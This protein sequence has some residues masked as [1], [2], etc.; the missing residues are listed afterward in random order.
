M[1]WKELIIPGVFFYP[2]CGA[3]TLEPLT[4][5]LDQPLDFIFCDLHE[6]AL[7]KLDADY[8]SRPSWV[9]TIS[10]NDDFNHY[11]IINQQGEE[12]C[13]LEIWENKWN[14][15]RTK[16]ICFREDA[17]SVF[18]QLSEI[19]IFFYRGDSMT[20]LG[21]GIPWLGPEL[22]PLVVNKMRNGGLMITDG[23]NPDTECLDT[24]WIELYRHSFHAYLDL[25]ADEIPQ[26]FI[27][28]NSEFKLMGEISKRYGNTYIWQIN[29]A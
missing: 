15:H 12:N 13:Y 2:C 1:K 17:R 22:F 11:T 19:V 16:I 3:D 7:P 25:Q 23:S 27:Y 14:Q 10:N 26:D 5:F 6:L 29:K 24:P 8:I 9:K 20:G 21:S 28:Q 4:L 18:R